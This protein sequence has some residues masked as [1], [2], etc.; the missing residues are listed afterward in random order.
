MRIYPTIPFRRANTA[1]RDAAALVA[2]AF[3]AAIGLWVF[4]AVDSLQ[5][6]GRGVHDAGTAVQTGFATAADKVGHIPL[7]GGP[8][9]DGLRSAG[10]ATGGNVADAGSRGEQRVHR[11]A[12]LLGLLT[13]LLPAGVLLSNY[14]PRRIAEIRTLNDASRV[15]LGGDDPERERLIAMRAAFSLP[16]AKLLEYTRDPL[17]DLAAGRHDALVRAIADEAGLDM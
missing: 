15:L 13:F 1:A 3:F 12:V 4:H 5:I 9:A 8:I 16:Y 14:L 2:V 17:G 10:Q 11:L 7:A 6:L